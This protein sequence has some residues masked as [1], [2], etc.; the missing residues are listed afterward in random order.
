MGGRMRRLSLVRGLRSAV[1]RLRVASFGAALLF[2]PAAQSAEAETAYFRIA[3]AGETGSYFPVGQALA[4]AVSQPPDLVASAITSNGSVA[5]A[6]AIA[7]GTVDSA[8]VQADV[9]HWAATGT[10]AFEAKGAQ[11]GLRAIAALYPEAVQLVVRR[12][13][14]I[15]GIES[16]S[17]KRVS[18]DEPGS[19]TLADVRLILAAHDRSE[20]D[21]EAQYF[22]ADLAARMVGDG[23]LDGF[24]FVGGV[25]SDAIA[26][27][28][29]RKP[30]EIAL[31]PLTG[32]GVTRLLRENPFF[33]PIRLPVN[34]YPQI[35]AVETVGVRALW[36]TG[37]EQP[38]ELVERLTA[39]L[40][41]EAG[42]AALD[43]GPAQAR[44]IRLE[45]ALD[46]LSVPLHPGAEAFYR[47]AGLIK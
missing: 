34:S 40:W 30:G 19:G 14:G 32:P 26:T 31:L 5:N 2:G 47:K 15:T 35:E 9:A 39:A 17:G 46:G 10:G 29:A 43:A 38:A 1:A 20:R 45:T 13:S 42:R 6:E 16:L 22:K 33:A 44:A 3:T 7:G 37:A 28:A 18:V 24:F 11:P 41:S 25:P 4:R 27:L 23:Y 12:D 36:L 8:L 21:F